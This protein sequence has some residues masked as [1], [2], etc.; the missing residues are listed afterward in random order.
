M[1]FPE[2]GGTPD[3][4]TRRIRKGKRRSGIGQIEA[5]LDTLDAGIHPIKPVRHICVLIPEIADALF[6]LAN[7]VAHVIKR[8]TDVRRCSS[9]I[10]SDYH[11]TK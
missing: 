8:A 6:Y 1:R 10:L 5:P 3:T 7:I 4:G 2:L 11:D 9:T